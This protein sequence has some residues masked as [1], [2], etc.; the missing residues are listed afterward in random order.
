MG[1]AAENEK[2]KLRATFLNNIATSFLITGFVVPYFAWMT[3]FIPQSMKIVTPPPGWS[4]E[5]WW[6]PFA[7]I[8]HSIDKPTALLL[9]ALSMGSVV[10]AVAAH[11]MAQRALNKMTD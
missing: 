4:W 10:A 5:R 6:S 9:V 11:M 1:K 8:Y 7:L 3:A 2:L